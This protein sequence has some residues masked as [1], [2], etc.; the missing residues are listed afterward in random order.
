MD[1][2]PVEQRFYHVAERMVHD[3]VT[4][5]ADADLAR[6][7]ITEDERSQRQ[8]LIRFRDKFPLQI[9][10][11]PHNVDLELLD[12]AL[13]GFPFPRFSKGKQHVLC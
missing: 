4:E 12:T 6:L 9:R 2:L 13:C 5:I 11:V 7:R 1:E 3:A 10:E 8:W